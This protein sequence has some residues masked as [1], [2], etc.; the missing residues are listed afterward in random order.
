MML[1]PVLFA[2]GLYRKLIGSGICGTLETSEISSRFKI[3]PPPDAA[4]SNSSVLVLLELKIISSP[5]DP[6]ARLSN[7]SATGKAGL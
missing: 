1:F 5:R 3:H 6:I 4:L 2:P 7:S